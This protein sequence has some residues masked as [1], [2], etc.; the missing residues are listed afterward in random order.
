MANNRIVKPVWRNT[1]NTGASRCDI[2]WCFKESKKTGIPS[3]LRLVK[4]YVCPCRDLSSSL[5]CPGKT[6]GIFPYGLSCRYQPALWISP[7]HGC[8]GNRSTGF[9]P[10]WQRL[11]FLSSDSLHPGTWEGRMWGKWICQRLGSILSSSRNFFMCRGVYFM[12]RT[13]CIKGILSVSQKPD[14][15][16]QKWLLLWSCLHN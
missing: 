3:H 1:G 6:H 15:G 9:F 12:V 13:Y 7:R 5:W 8:Q 14:T 4:G 11:F 2:G 10:T 16:S